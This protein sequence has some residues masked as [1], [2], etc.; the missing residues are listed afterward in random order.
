M[1]R[2]TIKTADGVELYLNQLYI[3]ADE[4]IENEYVGEEKNI[5]QSAA[6]MMFYI[7]D[8]IEKPQHDVELL[9][10]MFDS[11]VRICSKYQIL[12]TLEL[13]GLLTSIN[14]NTFS[15]WGNGEYRD[16][17][18]AFSLAVKKW[19]DICRGLVVNRLHNSPGTN[20]NLIFAA[21]ACYGMVETSPIPIENKEQIALQATNLPKLGMLEESED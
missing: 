8:R 3:L 17:T 16:V 13:F 7:A 12:P 14:P 1:N 20:A 19:K 5:S 4:F 11:F 21:K 18:P 10:K 9:D 2:N 15:A 6:A